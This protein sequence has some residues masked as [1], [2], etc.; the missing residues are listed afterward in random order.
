[1]GLF[2]KGSKND[3]EEMDTATPTPEESPLSEALE[4][5]AADVTG[6]ETPVVAAE[7]GAGGADME[8]EPEADSE[9]D[10]DDDLMDI[11]ASEEEQDV[12]LSALTDSLVEV[13]I[14][15]LLA[16][17]RDVLASLRERIEGK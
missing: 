8:D 9:E 10:E 17:T 3:S 12:D 11:F 6:A 1:M 13:D 16:E 5:T 15:S 2:D 4:D 14:E 7:E